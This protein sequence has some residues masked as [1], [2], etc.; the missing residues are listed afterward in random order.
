MPVPLALEVLEH[1]FPDA[2]VS[3]VEPVRSLGQQY[4]GCDSIPEARGTGGLFCDEISEIESH[5]ILHFKEQGEYSEAN[6]PIAEVIES[7]TVDSSVPLASELSITGLNDAQIQEVRFE[8]ALAGR[9]GFDTSSSVKR[10]RFAGVPER[11]FIG[12]EA[13]AWMYCFWQRI[14]PS[15]DVGADFGKEYGVAKEAC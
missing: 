6:K 12:L 2:S 11:C 7:E 9:Q 8:L 15:V 14:D 10:Y 1:L 4:R 13:I 5:W 3:E